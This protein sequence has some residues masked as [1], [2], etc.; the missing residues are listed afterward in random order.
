MSD[1]LKLKIKGMTCGSCSNSITARVSKFDFTDNVN[2]DW[3]AGSG[4]MEIAPD[5]NENKAKVLQVI[6]Q[7]GYEVE[8]A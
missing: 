7:M 5:F 6:G 8:E 4:S 2:V 1:T 3:E